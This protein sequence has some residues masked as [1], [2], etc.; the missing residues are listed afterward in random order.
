MLTPDALAFLGRLEAAFGGRR[1]DLLARRAKRQA[2]LATGV[3]PR[4]PRGTASVRAGD[5]QVAPSPVLCPG[6][7][8]D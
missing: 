4:F 8:L 6:Q 7:G 2:E 3:Q 1:R 5:W